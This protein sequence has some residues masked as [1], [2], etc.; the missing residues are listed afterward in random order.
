MGGAKRTAGKRKRKRAE[1]HGPMEYNDNSDMDIEDS[2]G[3]KKEG[4]FEYSL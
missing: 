3:D 4:Q 2:G 1:G